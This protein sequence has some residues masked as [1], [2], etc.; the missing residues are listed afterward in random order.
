MFENKKVMQ[1]EKKLPSGSAKRWRENYSKRFNE[2]QGKIRNFHF[3]TNNNRILSAQSK[4]NDE[5]DTF[6]ANSESFK[7][8]KPRLMATPETDNRHA[9]IYFMAADWCAG[10]LDYLIR[11]NENDGSEEVYSFEEEGYTKN[12]LVKENTFLGK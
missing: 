2:R 9:L 7:Q 8:L 5:I 3:S 12:K 6:L 4:F 10:S 11:E 1:Q